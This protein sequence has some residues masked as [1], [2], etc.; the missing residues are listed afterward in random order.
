MADLSISLLDVDA[1]DALYSRYPGESARQG[2]F[3]A[4]DLE[5]GELTC[6][7]N[8]EIGGGVPVSVFHY[9]TLRWDIPCLTAASA[10]SLMEA[11]APLAVRVLA[12]AEI[13][14]DGN[15][16]V[17]VLDADADGAAEEINAM[18]GE[19][20]FDPSEQVVVYDASD[21]FND[22]IESALESLVN[23]GLTP[24]SSD[25][26]IE[27]L[28][29]QVQEEAQSC[30]QGGVIVVDGVVEYIVDARN[31]LRERVNA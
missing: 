22:G 14:W 27:A 2:C 12:G 10:N 30:S 25:E 24:D 26:E 4:L 31:T 13:M 9:R 7:S 28:A 15:N 18:C 17:G 6:D 3:L 8:P 16:F 20:N 5:D 21:W 1:P 29:E 19:E 23:N 11:V